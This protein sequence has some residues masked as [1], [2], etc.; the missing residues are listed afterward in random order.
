MEVGAIP[1]TEN[2]TFL[3]YKKIKGDWTDVYTGKFDNS[4]GAEPEMPRNQVNED[5]SQT[6]SAGLHVCSYEYLPSFGTSPGNRVVICE[7]NPRDVVSIP[8]DYNNTKMRV[9][10][11]KVIGEVEDYTEEDILSRQSV[12]TTEEVPQPAPEVPADQL[13]DH[14]KAVGKMIS[15]ELDNDEITIAHVKSALSSLNVYDDSIE[16]ILVALED[17]NHRKIGKAIS[18]AIKHGNL[19]PY[20]FED[21]IMEI[22][23][24]DGAPDYHDDDED[25]DETCYRCSGELDG[26]GDCAICDGDEEDELECPRCATTYEDGDDECASCGYYFE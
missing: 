9:C 12:M 6:C 16:S 14:G 4:I 22:K 17:G 15:N 23:A 2:G 21:A 8:D 13:A 19:S 1:I 26:N 11:Y 7:V 20:P 3:T 25:E 5:S 18:K 10:R 24:E